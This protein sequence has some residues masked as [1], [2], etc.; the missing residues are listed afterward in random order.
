MLEGR[1][2]NQGEVKCKVIVDY[3]TMTQK[4]RKTRRRFVWG[5]EAPGEVQ[6]GGSSA[7][8]T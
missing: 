5:S 1:R 2:S 8:V 3:V 4:E 7:G 6:D